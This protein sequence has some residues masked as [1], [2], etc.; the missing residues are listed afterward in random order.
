MNQEVLNSNANSVVERTLLAGG[1]KS[2]AYVT[3]ESYPNISKTDTLVTPYLSFTG[4]PAGQSHTFNIPRSG[5]NYGGMLRFR[6]VW[7]ADLPSP[8]NLSFDITNLILNVQF[9]S[10][11]QP[12]LTITGE[13]YR[14]MLRNLDNAPLQEFAKKY[15][16]LINPTFNEPRA[17]GVVAAAAP[18]YSYLPILASWYS[19]VEKSLNVGELTQIQ[20]VVTYK[21]G[22]AQMGLSAAPNTLECSFQCLRYMPDADTYKKMLQK[23][24]SSPL[25]MESFNTITERLPLLAGNVNGVD[26]KSSANQPIYKTHVFVQST[27]QVG[28][29]YHPIKDITVSM[30]GQPYLNA[31][32]PQ[33]VNFN[34]ALKGMFSNGITATSVLDVPND[35]FR[36]RDHVLTIDWSLECHR[37]SNTGLASFVGL[38]RP[39]FTVT[40]GTVV[41]PDV[42]T[43]Y[44]LFLV[45]EYW[46]VLEINS[47]K[48]LMIRSST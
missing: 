2:L 12:V 43:N 7:D 48:T 9:V 27:N 14:A 26:F 17:A 40:W 39:D 46:N 37:D 30:G 1:V 19:S 41:G 24:F 4:S 13:A 18:N 28:L 25:I 15:G 34:Q 11:G 32:T 47:E 16:K 6:S 33:M 10:A 8:D 21:G 22:A 42:I 29:P 20:L 3:D 35:V 44:S 38:N 45:H 36:A 5:F 31:Y 23:D